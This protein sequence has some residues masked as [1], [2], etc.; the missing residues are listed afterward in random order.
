MLVIMLGAVGSIAQEA[1]VRTSIETKGDLWV[2]Q[3]ATLLVEL[4]VPG[5]FSGAAAFD[6]PT[7][8]GL[9][10]APPEGSPIVASETIDGMTYT[11]Q[12]HELAV[13][14]RRAG[15]QTIPPFTVRFRFKRNPLDKDAIPTA[16]KTEPVAFTVKLPPGAEK[17]GSLISAR[18]LKV[19]EAWTPEPGKAKAGDA[20]T[21]TITFDAPEVPA[22]AFPPFP[23]GTIDGIGVYPKPPEVARRKEPRKS[24]RQTTR[25]DHLRMP[26]RRPVHH[27]AHTANLVRPRRAEAPNNRLSRTALERLFESRSR[28]NRRRARKVRIMDRS[29][30]APRSRSRGVDRDAPSRILDALGFP[31][32]RSLAATPSPTAEPQWPTGINRSTTSPHFAQPIPCKKEERRC[33]LISPPIDEIALGPHGQAS[34]FSLPSEGNGLAPQNLLEN[35]LGAAQPHACRWIGEHTRL[36]NSVRHEKCWGRE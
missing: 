9:M 1:K 10:L 21:R 29:V 33:R 26:A 25:Y 7:V 30:L 24:H 3:R 8:P 16:V 13:F 14:S 11:V 17:L 36:A 34:E 4:L 31:G 5:F 27:S 2:G 15:E 28:I 18:N 12:R 35:R 19:E 23:A 22:M 20:F 32:S 6:L